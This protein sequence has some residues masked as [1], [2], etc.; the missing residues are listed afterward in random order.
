MDGR[1]IILLGSNNYLGLCDDSQLKEAA[2]DAIN[3]YGVGAGGS[4]L[5]TGSCDLHKKL[6]EKIADF[7]GTE[8]A[9]VYNTGYM[10]NVGILSA[11]CD[12]KWTIF[13]DKANH[14]SILDG[15]LLSGAKLVRYKHGDM[16][17][18]EKKIHMNKGAYNLIVTD[19]VFSMDGDI[20]PL[21]HIVKLAKKHG[22]LTMV[23][24]AH[25]VGVLGENGAGTASY[26]GVNEEIDVQMGTLSKA[27]P[28]VGGYVAGK[29]EIIDYLKNVSKSF[30][31]STALPPSAIAVSLEAIEMIQKDKE[32]R[33]RL[34]NLAT[35]FKNELQS[36]GFSMTNT[37]TPIIPV[38]IGD[39][40][41]TVKLSESLL[42]EGIY[43]PGIRPPTVPK[44]TSRLR[45]SIM[46][47]HTYEDL[48]YV[49]KVIKY[50]GK[51]LKIIEG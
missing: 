8:K 36:M 41:K 11:L 14:A 35:W 28:S 44:G 25:G 6:E 19:G 21:S 26:L 16:D 34:K 5:T 12:R 24:D 51:R 29:K 30:I 2:I 3:K 31:F 15:C 37:I 48:E 13:C 46:A 18:L 22:I 9:L 7:K 27:I 42:E 1:E 23:D 32:R 20:A 43:I 49:L 4:R 40:E 47:T 33:E 39:V 38:I 17:D 45:I 50:H 10:A